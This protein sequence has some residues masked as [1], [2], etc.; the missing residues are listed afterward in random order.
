MDLA[1]GG[2]ARFPSRSFL[3]FVCRDAKIKLKSI[4]FYFSL[5]T[6]EC[7]DGGCTDENDNEL[8]E[9][10]DV[11]KNVYFLLLITKFPIIPYDTKK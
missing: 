9:L 10:N 7:T 4:C 3:M 8:D 5:S 1:D 6:I 2:R 11:Q